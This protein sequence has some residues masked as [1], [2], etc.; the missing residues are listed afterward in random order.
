M[1][2]YF[3]TY[4]LRIRS[5]MFKRSIQPDYKIYYFFDTNFQ[6]MFFP[7]INGISVNWL[8]VMVLPVIISTFT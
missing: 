5:G 7:L 2:N 1:K 4:N 8:I 6:T 3:K